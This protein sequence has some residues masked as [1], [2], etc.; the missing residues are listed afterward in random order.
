VGQTMFF[1]LIGILNLVCVGLLPKSLWPP[2]A[3][4]GADT[5]NLIHLIVLG[6]SVVVALANY[7]FNLLLVVMLVRDVIFQSTLEYRPGP[8]SPDSCYRSPLVSFRVDSFD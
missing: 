3:F 1:I 7:K 8:P 4:R 5:I 6:T 2:Y